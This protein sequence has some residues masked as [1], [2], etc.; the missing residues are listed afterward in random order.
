MVALSPKS[1]QS[2]Y[3]GAKDRRAAWE[4]L[5]QECYDY[6]LPTRDTRRSR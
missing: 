3:Q 6:A 5:W 2:R 4:G 1:L